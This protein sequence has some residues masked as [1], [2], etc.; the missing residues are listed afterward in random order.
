MSIHHLP[1]NS[2][3]G[4]PLWS[5]TIENITVSILKPRDSSKKEKNTGGSFLETTCDSGNTHFEMGDK[6]YAFE[7]YPF[8]I[9]FEFSMKQ[10][11]NGK[12]NGGTLIEWG[13]N[14]RIEWKMMDGQ[15][16]R[17][18]IIGEKNGETFFEKSTLTLIPKESTFFLSSLTRNESYV[19]WTVSDDH[20]DVFVASTEMSLDANFGSFSV[21]RLCSSSSDDQDIGTK[22]YWSGTI[23]N[24]VVDIGDWGWNF[25]G[26]RQSDNYA[27]PIGSKM[28]SDK[29]TAEECN[30][31]AKYVTGKR[32]FC[33]TCPKDD[34]AD[35]EGVVTSEENKCKR[36]PC[37][38]CDCPNGTP[39]P[40]RQCTSSQ[41]LKCIACES[42]RG[43][44]LDGTAKCV[45]CPKT[46]ASG[47][48][49]SEYCA[50]PKK[51]NKYHFSDVG[52]GCY[53]KEDNEMEISKFND[54]R[55]AWT[56][57]QHW[58]SVNDAWWFPD[59]S[60]EKGCCGLKNYL[61]T[62]FV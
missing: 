59:K 53:W 33:E 26:A 50:V 21:A 49:E 30:I 2:I 7:Q 3:I 12:N 47:K 18:K 41:K 58:K 22:K 20:G 42:D 29:P 35:S 11:G 13:P 48:N 34:A 36:E 19:T 62:V 16:L 44:V 17:L 39:A 27:C 56:Y 14:N 5:G 9:S 38:S 61:F 1:F 31:A 24:L 6:L 37:I 43:F 23:R 10:A 51:V 45:S 28:L 57:H 54:C 60:K 40:D 25:F 8:R 52:K 55:A 4:P 15:K 46:I 32:V